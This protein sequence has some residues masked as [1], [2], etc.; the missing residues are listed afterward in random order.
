MLRV[1]QNLIE[2]G[3]LVR[4]AIASLNPLLIEGYLAFAPELAEVND[5][6]EAIFFSQLARLAA[7]NFWFRSRNRLIVWALRRFPQ[8]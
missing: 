3:E 8:A 2:W 5:G 7:R 4:L 1:G 6:F